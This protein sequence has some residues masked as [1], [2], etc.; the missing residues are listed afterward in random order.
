MS[1]TLEKN[2][3]EADNTLRLAVIGVGYVGLPLALEFSEYFEVIAFDT[4]LRRIQDLSV[5]YDVTKEVEKKE[6]Q[7]AKNLK[8]T[9][10]ETNLK[11]CDVFIV[12]VPTPLAVGNFPDLAHVRAACKLVGNVMSKGAYI[13]FESTVYPGATDEECIPI[14]EDISGLNCNE[15]FFVGYSPERINP[16]DKS[17]S[18][19]DIVK[20]T[21]GSNSE[22]TV[23]VD[24]LY[25]RII[26]AGTHPVSSIKV[27]EASKVIENTQRDINIAL[28]NELA[29]IFEKLQL[30]TNEVID[31]SSTKWN[32]ID[33]RPG[34]VG[35][36]CIGIDP[37][38]LTFRAEQIGIY[39]QLVLA[40][41]RVNN[42]MPEHVVSVLL[43]KMLQKKINIPGSKALVM[44]VTFKENCPDTRNSKV[45]EVIQSL[46]EYGLEIDWHDP[47]IEEYEAR[48]IKKW[49]RVVVLPENYY[50][51]VIIAVPH[52]IF[53]ELG[54]KKIN[55]V[56]KPNSV[57]FDVKAMLDQNDSDLRL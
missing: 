10:I 30:D 52:T 42:A 15:D 37:Y 20:V 43:K 17:K 29:V 8:F 18:I 40:G 46:D 57:V 19:A 12:T 34:L 41:R 6:L 33:F 48:K 31:A 55:L 7:K 13:I 49:K 38:Y 28:V 53:L 36:H 51:T 45:F 24:N 4:D 16:G 47:W 1:S 26:K 50:D 35:G 44:G 3:L 25:K 2:L 56:A 23:F 54:A 39:S 5:D 14:L 21:S 27:A 22:A 32:F 9:S 11:G